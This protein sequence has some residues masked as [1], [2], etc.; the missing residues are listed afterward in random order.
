MSNI[1]EKPITIIGQGGLGANLT[2]LLLEQ[3]FKNITIIDADTADD[4][5]F[6]RFPYF[7]DSRLF[8]NGR[9][10]V[11]VIKDIANERG[12]KNNLTYRVH[13]ITPDSDFSQFEGHFVIISVDTLSG[14]Q[15]IELGLQKRGI[16]FVHVGCNLNKISIFKTALD[17]IGEDPAP[18]A[19]TSYTE[20]P[21][22]KTYMIAALEVLDYINPEMITISKE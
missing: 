13:M 15:N 14:R 6:K 20:I 12:Y 3:G 2:I 1:F 9:P 17:I 11:K 7:T 18:D 5:F 19:Q 22:L 21:D 8:N 10:K 16:E 4:K